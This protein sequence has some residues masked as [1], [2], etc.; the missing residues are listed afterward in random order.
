MQDQHEGER[1]RALNQYAIMGTDPEEVYDRYVRFAAQLL[2]TPMA[3][4]GLIGQDRQWL[5]AQ[6]GL[7][8]QQTSCVD[9]LCN[10]TMRSTQ[11][12]VV[13][14][15][16][17]DPRFR[18]NPY[19]EGPPHAR[20]Y[21]GVPLV[22]PDGYSIGTL[23]VLDTV[24]RH[25]V[26]PKLIDVLE[27]LARAV[28]ANLELR[29]AATE[30]AATSRELYDQ[31]A[32]LSSIY[33]TVRLGIALTDPD[34]VLY[35][36]NAHLGTLLSVN[37]DALMGR[38]LID[39]LEPDQ[40]EQFLA[41]ARQAV[42]GGTEVVTDTRVLPEHAPPLDASI[43]SRPLVT[44]TGEVLLL[45]AIS[46]ITAERRQR[47][48]AAARAEV[49][50]LIVANAPVSD[51]LHRIC[52]LLE[53]Q[54][55]ESLVII[56]RWHRGMLDS[57]VAPTMTSHAHQRL[58]TVKRSGAQSFSA[59]AALQQ[60]SMEAADLDA[61]TL[62]PLTRELMQRQGYRSIRAEP[63][64]GEGGEPFGVIT[65]VRRAAGQFSQ[66]VCE[67]LSEAGRLA[68]LALAHAS[69]LEDLRQRAYH[70]PLTGLGNRNLLDDRLQQELARARRQGG[71][72]GLVLLDLD[73]FK[74][75]NDS[76]GHAAGDRVLREIAER[77]R[78]NTR[79]E[80]VVCRLG[81][82]EFVLAF[83][84]E[85][86]EDLLAIG[87]KVL[88]AVS[89]P[90]YLEGRLLRTTPSIGVAIYPQDADDADGLLRAADG[91][92]YAAKEVGK[93]ALRYYDASMSA[94]ALEALELAGELR[95]AVADAVFDVDYQGRFDLAAGK[96]L[97]LEALARWPHPRRGRLEA[98][99]FIN[100]AETAGVLPALDR[101]VLS[102]SLPRLVN[103]RRHQPNLRL[104]WNICSATLRDPG[105]IDWLAGLLD[106]HE[107]PPAALEIELL[108]GQALQYAPVVRDRL[109]ELRTRLPGVRVGL[110]DFGL[111]HGALSVLRRIPVDALKIDRQLVAAM[112][113]GEAE[114]RHMAETLIH[115][116][117]IV[118]S[119][120]GLDV[121]VEGLESE[122]QR[123]Q[124]TAMGCTVMQGWLF[125]APEP[126][127][128]VMGLQRTRGSA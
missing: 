121:V 3:S 106:A 119:R 77:L 50:G 87:L 127:P 49:M 117:V 128:D 68:G 28:M 124:L 114:D 43:A 126:E 52:H 100:Q 93:N 36:G 42:E 72:L 91:A 80:D 39:F 109:D 6:I 26:D 14:D 112:G 102:Q 67:P 9:A 75:I 92:M 125:H 54:V 47:R 38:N 84:A 118:A 76:L 16:L 20:F 64:M 107:L 65:L 15:L 25:R 81:G 101:H 24:P 120:F 78:D 115:A 110:D 30:I 48:L 45:S 122:T 63:L 19:V 69:M 86:A 71:V 113:S 11:P 57:A 55:P 21:A 31:Q 82:D 88:E 85:Q 61:L 13:S 94:Q 5:K 73:D 12:L 90:V 18:D 46:D 89:E 60:R 1:L 96:L 22:T 70:D 108:E 37:R 56:R 103:W 123:Q 59:E 17:E 2:N 116:V 74:L 83:Q 53:D 27:E 10:V 104:F 44:Q 111:D 62:W 98:S 95:Q 4:V 58:Q 7:D 41:G 79:D 33:D 34:G 32:L 40:R 8:V 23:C 51:V 99:A 29:R 66:E 97:G 105:F 35:Q